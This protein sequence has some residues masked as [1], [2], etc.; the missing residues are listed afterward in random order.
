MTSAN[1][2]KEPKRCGWAKNELAVRYHDT[3]WGVPT[4]DDRT[5]FEF[6]LLEGAQAGLS[7]D[8][9][10]GKREGYRAAFA[11]FDPARVARF[12]ER[13]K[14]RLLADKGI[15]RNRLKIASAITNARAFLA[16]QAEF[17]TFD[18]FLWDRFGNEP[19][20]NRW[21]NLSQIPAVTPEAEALSKEL[22]K[23]DFRFVGPTICY[24]YMQSLG[25]VND[26]L[27]GCFRHRDI[28]G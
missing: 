5:L 9:I 6:L 19:H 14:A 3:E 26:H 20:T 13:D 28:A 16:V 8:T 1:S 17:G 22:R 23:R 25:I 12:G 2:T 10:L 18:A 4:H 24:A 11:K 7:W 15:V 21:R 27:V